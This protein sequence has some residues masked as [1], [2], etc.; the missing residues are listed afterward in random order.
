M[1][2]IVRLKKFLLVLISLVI[3]A[4]TTG[5]PTNGEGISNKGKNQKCRVVMGD[6]GDSETICTPKQ[7]RKGEVMRRYVGE[8]INSHYMA[9][10]DKAFKEALAHSKNS[11]ETAGNTRPRQVDLYSLMDRLAG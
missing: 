4:C 11:R 2:G 7:D 6:Y 8:E 1:S 9:E 5:P 10:A 3:F